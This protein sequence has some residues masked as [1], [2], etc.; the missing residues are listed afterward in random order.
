MTAAVK[1][2]RY[3]NRGGG[4]K[5]ADPA[6]KR[7]AML[8]VRLSGRELESCREAARV[9]GKSASEWARDTLLL[10]AAAHGE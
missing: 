4:R 8:P 7:T 2:A 9:E 3:A 1:P 10:R 6:N 5:A